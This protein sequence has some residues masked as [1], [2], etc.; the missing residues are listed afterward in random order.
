MALRRHQLT[1]FS[2]DGT[3]MRLDYERH[4]GDFGDDFVWRSEEER[5]QYQ[6]QLAVD[7]LCS[8]E[9]HIRKS[10]Y[11]LPYFGAVH[12]GDD[13][14]TGQGR[15][16]PCAVMRNSGFVHPAERPAA[17]PLNFSWEGKKLVGRLASFV[18]EDCV[19]VGRYWRF[20]IVSDLKRIEPNIEVRVGTLE[21]Y[22]F[23]S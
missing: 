6:L 12:L 5:I 18:C 11:S 2:L 8:W 15:S 19:E 4:V 1:L 13:W 17:P 7:V 23:V 16:P 20:Y 3:D 21:T 14:L 9:I 22:P 10:R